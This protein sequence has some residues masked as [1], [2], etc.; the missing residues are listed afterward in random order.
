MEP[1]AC[2]A[3]AWWRCPNAPGGKLMPACQI[4]VAEGVTVKTDTP[5]VKDQQRATLEFLLLNHPVDCAHCLK[6]GSCELPRIAKHL[7]VKLNTKKFKKFLRDRPID[8]T[9]SAWIY[10]PNK[11]VLCGKCVWYCQEKLNNRTIG[12]AYRGFKDG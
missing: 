3:C 11:C 6:S 9:S 7:G 5:K 12:F 2:A 8:E 4:P 1:V 10:E